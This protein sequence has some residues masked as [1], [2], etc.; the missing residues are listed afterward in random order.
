MTT[1]YNIKVEKHRRVS[2]RFRKHF[3][4]QTWKQVQFCKKKPE[5][6]DCRMKM[7]LKL[8]KA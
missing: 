4:M 2:S 1:E 3:F 7:R 5:I 8:L 6:A